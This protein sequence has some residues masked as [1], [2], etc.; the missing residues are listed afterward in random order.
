MRVALGRK[1][2]IGD[3]RDIISGRVLEHLGQLEV[4]EEHGAEQ[5]KQRRITVW[6]E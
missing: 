1:G 6:E 5:R 4:G 2:R 3:V